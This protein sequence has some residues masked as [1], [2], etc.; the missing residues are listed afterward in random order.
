TD[1]GRNRCNRVLTISIETRQ[2]TPRLIADPPLGRFKFVE[3][4]RRSRVRKAR[5]CGEWPSFGGDSP[6]AAM[7]LV[8]PGIAETGLVMADDRIVPISDVDCAVGSDLHINRT[9]THIARNEQ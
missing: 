4:F 1:P 8:A 3:Q 6:D 7:R 2:C 5:L 9:K